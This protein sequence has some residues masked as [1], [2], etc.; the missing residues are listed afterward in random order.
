M[1]DVQTP[2]VD[3]GIQADSTSWKLYPPQFL[4]VFYMGDFGG[5][6]SFLPPHWI[7]P[8]WL[9]YSCTPLDYIMTF[10]VDLRLNENIDININFLGY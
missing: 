1:T 4:L 8:C 5:E 7:E 6:A 10:S 3:W 9:I 2:S